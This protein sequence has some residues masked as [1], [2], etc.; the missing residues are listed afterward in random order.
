MSYS[1]GGRAGAIFFAVT[2]MLISALADAQS[3]AGYRI[4]FW[5]WIALPTSHHYGPW[6]SFHNEAQHMAAATQACEGYAEQAGPIIADESYPASSGY[7]SSGYEDVATDGYGCWFKIYG[8]HPE[9]GKQSGLLPNGNE[10]EGGICSPPNPLRTP[11]PSCSKAGNPIDLATGN[12]YQVETDYR[13]AD[14][15]LEFSR[16]Y[17][18]LLEQPPVA[19][20]YVSALGSHWRS[21]YDRAIRLGQ[22]AH[23][24]VYAYRPDGKTFTFSASGSEFVTDPDINDRLAKRFDPSN[25][26]I[27]WRYT[28]GAT[29]EVELYDT[30]GRLLSITSR[31][32][33]TAT[34]GY[35]GSGRLASVTDS[36]GKALTFSY[37]GSN[38]LANLTVPDGQ[39]YIYSYNAANNVSGVA[40]PGGTTRSYIYNEIA[41][42]GGVSQPTAL[43]GIYD[44][45]S[46][47][48]ST[49]RYNA[50]HQV[51]STEHG[52]GIEKYEITSLANPAGGTTT[53]TDPLGRSRTLDISIIQGVPQVTASSDRSN[54]ACERHKSKTYDANGN[55][56]STIDF[57]DVETIH[58]V[59]TTR[60][61]EVMR[62][63]AATRQFWTQWHPTF[64]LPVQISGADQIT[65]HTHDADGNVLTVSVQ[66]YWASETRTST[67]T[68]NTFG[69]PLTVD[70]PRTDV[71]DTTTYS[72]YNCTTGYQ[73][74]Q[75]HTITNA[76]GHA[77]TYNTYNAHGQPLT[78]SDPNGVVTTLTYDLRQRITSRTVG[79]EV[80]T[81]TY[82]PTGLLKKATLPDASYLEY[83]Y[84][85]AH[86]LT[87]I[88]DSEG[89]RA[90]YTLDNMGNR[91]AETLY[92]PSN[93][94]TQTRMRVFDTLNRLWKEIGAAGTAAVTTTFGYDGNGNQTNIAAPLAR[95]TE[96]TYDVLNRLT[97]VTDPLSGVT[98]YGYN[99]RDQLTS[100][101]DPRS[102]VTYYTYNAF[103]DLLQQLSHDT[104]AT[105]KMYD[106]G[107]NL[108]SS[109][110][111]R[112]KTATYGYDALN[113]VTSLTFPDQTISYTYDTG[114]NQKGRLTQVTDNSG[115]TSWSYDTHGRVTS[116]QQSMGIN[117]TVSYGYDSYG[118]L[119]TLTLPSSNTVTY[120]YTDG[121]VTSL[122]LNGS[123][124][125]LANALYQPFGPTRGWTWG[126]STLAVREYD[127][128]GLIT[129]VD[130][131][132]LKA[133]G[134]DNAFRITGITDAS[135]AALSQ[136]YG[137]DLLDR[138]TTASGT[139]LNQSWT[140][141]ANGNRLTQGGSAP[142][143]Y[144]VS[145]ASNRLD[146]VS[147]DLT[148]SYTYDDVG[149]TTDDG[150]G[151]FVYN[152]AGRMVSVTK[153]SVT[154][155][156]ALNALGQRV[157][158][159]TGG[160]SRYFVYDEAEHLLGEYD[161]SGALIQETIWFGD[162][163]VA[164]LKP[165]GS[166]G[167]QLFYIHTDHLHT[168]RRISRPS[169]N[170]IVWRWDS[171]PFGSTAANEDPDGDNVSFAYNL[172][173]PGQYR[174][175]ETGLDY[176]YYRDGYDPATGRY[177][178]SDPIG[179]AGGINTYAYALSNPVTNIDPEGLQVATPWF[180]PRP[181]VTPRPLPLPTI[182][183][184]A[185]PIPDVG[186]DVSTPQDPN[187]CDPCKGLRDQLAAHEKKLRDY[188]ADPYAH[189]N[190]GFLG[191]GRDPQVIAGRI[192]N[193]QKQI[194]N[195]RKLLRECE[196]KHGA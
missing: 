20:P 108:T 94:L 168:P 57:N 138:L 37:D 64:R 186:T 187:N 140:Y 2:L 100:V 101:T 1:I 54:L 28:I 130:S 27:G 98:Q 118:R 105:T 3:C 39:S 193:L 158:K 70:G 189:D 110:D 15:L 196:I 133:Y 195:F 12:K 85:V 65:T 172:R 126:N 59:D 25:V 129:D 177:T 117:K 179:L 131:A 163:P 68:Y 8:I 9:Y 191:R 53:F 5:N 89:N 7:V 159:T 10:I 16:H 152:D 29:D 50:A 88:Q 104:G 144:T 32:G 184:P 74:G 132:G 122:T 175:Q 26:F 60:N 171:D 143:T 91:T 176:N 93:A 142:S 92:D 33:V 169:D 87:G 79:A 162:I 180:L 182:T 56:T 76:A 120:G 81:L 31:A 52:S 99:L 119:Q 155:T 48:Y 69:K 128:D 123:S 102:N 49:F 107:G 55:A 166:G 84:D 190:L 77:T 82:W 127:T 141:D 136:T 34:L 137:Y 30:N 86:R 148:R 80:T 114:T 161:A 22:I 72:Y 192:Q 71:S 165:N 188:I 124:T 63:E 17:N 51:V 19:T 61:L 153:A 183:D 73:C 95:T 109:T 14:G 147:G 83:S 145:G 4:R 40:Q 97:E 156:Y 103:G 121:K 41:Y 42:T 66:D 181:L 13:S 62:M 106:L 113:R 96:Q 194:D 11:G 174:D 36:F 111:A 43:T 150:A 170:V 58:W 21:T 134:Y 160:T 164:T 78:I 139:G 112:S 18:S 178:Q 67:R 157:K 23:P 47:R 185:L 135:N 44:E 35:D 24:M 45:S 38:R 151:T 167:V 90:V 146:N 125:I 149:N 6:V 115:S 46:G 75:V 173:F 116:R 154:T